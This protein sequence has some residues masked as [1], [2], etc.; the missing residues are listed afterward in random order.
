MKELKFNAK[1]SDKLNWFSLSRLSQSSW[2]DMKTQPNNFF[3]IR[4]DPGNGRHF[5]INSVYGGCP[6][7][8]G[9]MVITVPPDCDWE[10]RFQ[11]RQNVILYSKVSGLT[12][13]NQYGELIIK[14]TLRVLVSQCQ[15]SSLE[16]AGLPTK[17]DNGSIMFDYRLTQSK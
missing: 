8:A 1:G 10:K 14:K 5:F 17:G 15:A 11:P 16:I 13:W 4:G 9:W 12:N 3:S 7:D 2:T 6:K